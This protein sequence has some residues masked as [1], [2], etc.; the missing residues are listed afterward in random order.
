MFTHRIIACLFFGCCFGVMSLQAAEPVTKVA[1]ASACPSQQLTSVWRAV[2]LVYRNAEID[3]T[4]GDGKQQH[5][6]NK[7]ADEEVR[8]AVSSFR[9]YP[10]LAYEHSN[11][12]AVVQYDIV[13]PARAINSVTKCGK[14]DYWL[15]PNDARE[16]INKYAAKGTYDSILVL[17]PLSN[18]A[19]GKSVPS[20]GWGLAIGPSDW[21][22]GATYCTVGNAPVDGWNEPRPG[23]VW[24]HEWI[25]GVCAHFAAKGFTMPAGDADAGGSHGYEHSPVEGW[26]EFYQD[27]MN[28][29]VLDKNH[30]TGITK[31]AWETGAIFRKRQ[32]VAADNFTTDT[33]SCYK[34]TGNVAWT[35]RGGKHENI[36]L[37]DAQTKVSR[38]LL[39]VALKNRA[40]ITARVQVPATGAGEQDAVGVVLS[41]GKTELDAMLTYGT[42]AGE[43]GTI[44][45]QAGKTPG[46]SFPMLLIPGWYTAK[47][48]FDP[49][50]KTLSLKVWSDG[51]QEPASW[52]VTHDMTSDWKPTE[53][54]FKQHGQGTLVDDLVIIQEP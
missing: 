22:N 28:G 1:P 29:R 14:D 30:R 44:C 16:E 32:F 33:T 36:A 17:A 2:L 40:T 53:I 6:S 43:K 52:H 23:E 46:K 48:L 19:T 12:Q 50:A 24:L 4:D 27:L 31:A 7:L 42:K 49:V 10:S 11:R 25:H 45:I 37:G 13:Y 3:Y 18:H 38:M 39:P 15:S 35:G 41:D 20:G 34:T 8:A 9:Q 51:E 5:F 21:S 26:G 47:L 54:G